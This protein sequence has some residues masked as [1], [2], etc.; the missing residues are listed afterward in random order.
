VSVHLSP[1][2]RRFS[3]TLAVAAVFIAAA[4]P[5]RAAG[6][7][8]QSDA[9]AVLVAD[10]LTGEVLYAVNARE[11]LP[12]ASI[13]KLMTAIVVLDRARPND[14]VT[15]PELF[16]TAVEST[17]SLEEGERLAVRDLL[18][19]ALIQS[20]ND[21]AYALAAHVG[22]G[23][24]GAFVRLMNAKAGELGLENTRFVRPDGLD[25]PGHYS[26]AR[27]VFTLA[28]AAMRRPLIRKLVRMRGGRISGDRSLFAWN[29]LLGR[30]PGLIGVK[31]GHTSDAGWCQVA[32]ARRD[33][34]TTY[35][36]ILGSPTRSQRNEDL[37]E[38]LEW[39]LAQYA[40]VTVVDADHRY[41]SAAIPFSDERLS[42]VAGEAGRAVVRLGRPL[43]ETVTAPARVELP[44][45]RGERLGEIVVSDGTRVISRRP[46]VARLAV[47][48]AS[49][50]E[51]AGWYAD[52]ALDEAGGMLAGAFG[53]IL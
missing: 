14:V 37:A 19:A 21:A 12:Q 51:R 43:V 42:L 24:V 41:A 2:L 49:L 52:Q 4:G 6:A 16:P 38:L 28:R 9:K 45:A 32:A 23:D 29:D 7:P 44:V 11:R 8:P 27:D 13:T 46:L 1:L 10:G 18:A 25:K 36:V 20:A 40:K 3:A 35:A 15:V 30:F 53:A 26:T 31:T 5:A 34:V 39:G 48:Q 17:I 50:G 33:G 22:H 47:R